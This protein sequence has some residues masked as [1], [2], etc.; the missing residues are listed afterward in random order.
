MAAVADSLETLRKPSSPHGVQN[1]FYPFLTS[2]GLRFSD[3]VLARVV[4]AVVGPVL[5]RPGHLLA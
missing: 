2:Y 3:N 4:D 1:H 5:E